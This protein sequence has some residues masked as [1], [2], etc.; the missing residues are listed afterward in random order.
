MVNGIGTRNCEVVAEPL[1]SSKFA[2]D[3]VGAASQPHIDGSA[4]QRQEINL[5]MLCRGNASHFRYPTSPP[6]DWP[7]ASL[8]IQPLFTGLNRKLS[9]DLAWRYGRPT[10]SRPHSTNC[11]I[12]PF[13][14]LHNLLHH[15]GLIILW[16]CLVREQR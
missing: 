15:S 6:L 8:G 3:Q 12:H 14:F 5:T 7:R 13:I 16:S 1:F 11:F 4:P 9:K 2:C 10:N